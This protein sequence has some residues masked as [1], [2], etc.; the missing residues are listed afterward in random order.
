MTVRTYKPQIQV[1][2]V[3][4]V[5]RKNGV[6]ARHTGAAS[7]RIDLTPYLGDA[8]SVRTEKTLA[9]PAGSFSLS[10]PDQPDD[11]FGDTL[12]AMIEPMDVVEI[13]GA[14]RPEIYV[15]Q[16]LPL[17]MR[18]FVSRVRR[19][20]RMA[21][22][23][24]P[25]R[26]V[27]VEGQDAGKLWLVNHAYFQLAMLTDKDY[28]TG[29]NLQV[30]VG[31]D[32]ALLRAGDYM[33]ELV[34]KVM[35]GK[36]G[37]LN[38][39]AGATPYPFVEDVM[40]LPFSTAIS[41][42]YG[43]VM[44][45]QMASWDAV[46]IWSLVE[47]FADRPW[48]EV[49]IQDLEDGPQFVFRPAPYKDI[50]GNPIFTDATDPGFV[51]VDI[52]DVVALDMSRSDARIANFF[53]VPPGDSTVLSNAFLNVASLSKQE[54]MDFDYPN[55]QP[56]IY[57]VR[58]MS[59]PTNLLMANPGQVPTMLPQADRAPVY[60]TVLE[61][62]QARMRQLKLMNRDNGVFEEGIA[63]LKGSETLVVGKYLRLSRGDLLSESYIERV[64]HTYT[65]L[66]TWTTD[67]GLIRG[68]GFIA[69]GKLHGS[70]YFAEGRAGPYTPA[71]GGV[72]A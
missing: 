54:G 4:V 25:Q 17:I 6:A 32:V 71:R 15:N 1:V 64:A 10:F 14:R 27:V 40:V 33:A 35:N 45:Q 48:N 16:K 72:P 20:E 57:G 68:T 29:F 46:T 39:I 8:G 5:T 53:W 43:S 31:I 50:R 34:N 37:A 60:G 38:A 3:K 70:P 61:W 65:P 55:N 41:V 26:S 49:F 69:R 62:Y 66:Q 59:V 30:A 2:L 7:R 22:D 67:V 44:P 28:L 18:G 24:T 47:G 42:Q 58:R 19:Q 52:A 36:V 12:Y 23:G 63:T 13:R 51:P 21:Q 11:K 9:A 56:A